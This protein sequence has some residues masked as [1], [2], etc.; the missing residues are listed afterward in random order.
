MLKFS[1]VPRVSHLPYLLGAKKEETLGT[2][3]VGV[4]PVK[5]NLLSVLVP[6]GRAPF[7]QHPESRPLAGSDF[8]SMRR[9][10][11]SDLT[12]SMRR[13]AGSP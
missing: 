12:P 10:F 1:I 4:A 3:L 9:E 5:F 11:A 2:R 13:V 6:K 8:L 7:G